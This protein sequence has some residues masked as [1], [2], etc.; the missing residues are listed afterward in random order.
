MISHIDE[1]LG[2]TGGEFPYFADPATGEWETLDD[3]T[4]AGGH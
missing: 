3:G 1:T 4:W 2:Q